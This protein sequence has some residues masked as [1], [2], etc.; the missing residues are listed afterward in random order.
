MSDVHKEA[1]HLPSRPGSP[2]SP[3]K[4]GE[5]VGY[6]RVAVRVRPL[7]E[8]RG[9]ASE[10]GLQIHARA[11][12][13]TSSGQAFRFAHVFESEH[14]NQ[15]LFDCLGQP[16]VEASMSGYNGTIFC[17]GQTG[18]GKTYTMGE[19]SKIGTEHEGVGHRMIR[20]LYREIADDVQHVYKVEVTFLQVYV[21]RIY[22]L[23]AETNKQHG[24][25]EELALREDKTEGVVVVGAKKQSAK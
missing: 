21:E 4:D 17:Y 2:G 8:D 12:T 14:D 15:A 7:G 16:L 3:R 11:G 19:S 24:G 20:A 22:D 9:G 23:L 18:S 10:D 6:M 25:R 13:I 5:P 1:E